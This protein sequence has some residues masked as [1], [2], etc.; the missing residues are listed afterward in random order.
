MECVE[1]SLRSTVA[2]QASWINGCFPDGGGGS[3][4]VRSIA[5]DGGGGELYSVSST[6]AILFSC[7][8]L[9]Y[10]P[11]QPF[12]LVFGVAWEVPKRA[13]PR[14]LVF[15]VVVMVAYAHAVAHRFDPLQ[16][17]VFGITTTEVSLETQR[18]IRMVLSVRGGMRRGWERSDGGQWESWRDR[19]R[20]RVH[21]FHV[22]WSKSNWR[23]Y[24]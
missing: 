18:S 8:S 21:G 11:T 16:V 2:A 3:I 15:G 5:G 20:A 12:V 22:L 19:F 6:C 1:G 14:A 7:F 4:Y 24:E 13:T 23:A 9:K 17:D 10:G